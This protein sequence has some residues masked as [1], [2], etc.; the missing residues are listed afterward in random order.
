VST[1]IDAIRN[2]YVNIYRYR[3]SLSYCKSDKN[4]Y[5]SV[6]TRSDLYLG[7][8]HF[9]EHIAHILCTCPPESTVESVSSVLEKIVKYAVGP[10]LLPTR[11]ILKIWAMNWLFVGMEQTD[12]QIMWQHRQWTLPWQFFS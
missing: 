3:D 6:F 1:S 8:E 12:Q 9:L 11:K 7:V 5:H 2:L 10:K 4:V